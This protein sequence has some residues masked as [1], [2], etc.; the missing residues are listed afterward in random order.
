LLETVLREVTIMVPAACSCA[1]ESYV[2]AQC[3]DT[4]EIAEGVL[5][6]HFLRSEAYRHTEDYLRGLVADVERKNGWQLAEYAGYAHPRGIQ[7][8]LDRYA[9]D[10]DAVRDDLRTYV[11]AELGEP[12]G[13]LV[14]DETGFPKQGTHSVGVARQYCGTLGKIANCQIG[15]FLGYASS[16]GHVGLDR[17]LFVP[18]GWTRDPDRC[19]GVG[20]PDGLPYRTKPQLALEMVER[21][22][23][24]GVPAA[25][26]V[27]DEVYGSDGKLRRALEERG[28]AYVLAVRSNEATTTW[29]PYGPPAQLRVIDL[30]GGVPAE[31]WQPLSCGEG[32]QGP[33]VYDWAIVPLRPAL[34]DGWVHCLLVRRHPVQADEIAYYLVYAPTN[35]PLAE[36]VRAAGARWTIDDVFKLA[37]GQVGLDHYEV[38]SWHGWYRHITLALLALAALT[39]GTRK[40]GDL[41]A[42]ST[43]PSPSRKSAGFSSGLSGAPPT[44]PSRSWSGPVGGGTTRESPRSATGGAA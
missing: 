44:R 13:I 38:R 5:Q 8:V 29:P 36:I 35:T 12:R 40:R 6:P 39:V 15:V 18:E 26:V 16:K 37:K 10:A 20:I 1:S 24:A 2:A 28:Q 32:A 7:R 33:R 43:S 11:V 9:W 34:R 30:A 14:V 22:L 23:D 25:W 4:V 42:P 3:A 31:G 19:R 17:A 41:L 27:G 21:A